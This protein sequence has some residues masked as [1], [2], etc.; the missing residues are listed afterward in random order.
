MWSANDI[1]REMRELRPMKSAAALER[2]VTRD[3][4]REPQI[5][6]NTALDKYLMI[7]YIYYY[8]LSLT[9]FVEPTGFNIKGCL[10]K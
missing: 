9:S 3:W 1:S 2:I 7:Y 8:M 6:T 4:N 10:I 5:K